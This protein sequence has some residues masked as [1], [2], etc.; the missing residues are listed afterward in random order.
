[1][2]QI[3]VSA[4]F[5]LIVANAQSLRVKDSAFPVP[6]Y[7]PVYPTPQFE[8]PDLPPAAVPEIDVSAYLGRLK[9]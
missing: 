4:T 7:P 5:L 2:S 8:W 1:M 9:M 3:I 6:T